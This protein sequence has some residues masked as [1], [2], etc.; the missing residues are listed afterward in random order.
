[1]GD[2]KM[3]DKRILM[4]ASLLGICMLLLFAITAATNA[5]AESNLTPVEE[6][7]KLIFFDETL[8]INENQSCAACHKPDAGWVG[9]DSAINAGGSVYEGSIAGR[10]GDRK[11][12][13]A[14]YATQSPIL[15][16]VIE[17]KEPL[18]IGGNFWDGR[19]T[20][21]LLGNPAADQA[22]GPFLN[23]VEQ[24]LEEPADVVNK[25]CEGL[26]ADQ[27]TE[28][29]GEEACD[30]DN[31]EMAYGYIGLSIAAYEASPEVNA[32]TSKY[33]YT[34]Q[35]R[36]KLTKEEQRG[37]AL[38][39]GKG[40]CHAC[41]TSNGQEALFTDYTYDNLGVPRNSENPVYQERGYEWIDEGLG[42]F[43]ATRPDYAQFA[44]DNVGKHK[45]PTLRNVGLGSCEADPYDPDCIVKAYGHNGYFKSLYGIVHFYNTR[46]IL[47]TCPDPFTLEADALAM[48]CWPEPEVMTN[49]NTDELG[50]LGLTLEEEQAL[51]AFLLTLSDG[52]TP[53]R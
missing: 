17:K 28:I 36:A 23:P 32:F 12:P 7:G 3:N 45:V 38:F 33:D 9:P 50:D 5:T 49:V 2:S 18:F 31:V 11:P 25:V 35:G 52:Y 1:M 40:Q 46:D 21:E 26:Y 15:H 53:T 24:A 20:G 30:P 44:E 37:Y 29:W 27:F 10:F 4:V 19:A 51:V 14:A 42:A 6:L 22:L 16:Y 41:H 47:P 34:F 13:S 39:R 8:S 43:L 48:N